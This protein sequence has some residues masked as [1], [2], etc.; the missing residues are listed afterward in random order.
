M[1]IQ[2]YV[3]GYSYTNRYGF[4][5]QNQVSMKKQDKTKKTSIFHE[6]QFQTM[7]HVGLY[8]TIC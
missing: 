2:T 5:L 3:M 7:M 6:N 1:K 4:I 8:G